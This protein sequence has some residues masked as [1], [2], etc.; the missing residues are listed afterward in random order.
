MKPITLTLVSETDL[1]V[2]KIAAEAESLLRPLL[3]K[4]PGLG[5][6]ISQPPEKR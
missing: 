5:L 1:D 2:R 4:H 3:E 6:K